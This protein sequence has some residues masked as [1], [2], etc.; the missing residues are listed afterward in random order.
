[1]CRCNLLCNALTVDVAWLA[2]FRNYG[3]AAM[4]A[5]KESDV[6]SS[7]NSRL[8]AKPEVIHA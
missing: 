1:M 4:R 3:S 7:F 6:E 8:V 2:S 5:E